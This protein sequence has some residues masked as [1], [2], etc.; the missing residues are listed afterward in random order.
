MR[1]SHSQF[2][3]AT[4]IENSSPTIGDNNKRIDQMEKCG[5]YKYWREDFALVHEMGISVLRYGPPLFRTY[6]GHNRYDWEFS[7][8]AFAEMKEL[9]LLP[10]ADLCHFG[11][12]D[13][14]GNFQNPDFPHLFAEYAGAFAQR[15]PWVQAY[16]PVNEMFICATF[17]AA[18]G[19]WNER[20]ESDFAF[21]TA[22]KHIVKANVLAMHAILERRP[23]AIF[24]QSES[25]EYFHADN[26]RAIG[27]AEAKNAR[28]FLS[29][30]LNYGR[31]VNSDVYEYLMDNGMTRGEY[32]FFMNNNLKHHC[33]LGTD[34]Y[35]TNEHRVAA[36]G[37]T[38]ASGE[39]FGFNELAR[40]YYDRYRLPVMH[41]ETNIIEGPSGL[42]AVNW[43]WKQFA[44]V[45]RV[46]NS[47]VPTLGF[48]WYSLTDQVD[49]DTALRVENNNQN[50]LGLYDLDR[51]IRNVGR[52]YKQLIEEWRDVLPTQSECLILPLVYPQE[53][54]EDWAVRRRETMRQHRFEKIISNDQ[55]AAGSPSA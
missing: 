42:E 30:D 22:L 49:W 26:P 14:I 6:I 4:G 17:S 35:V 39:I 5:H 13:W 44:N 51:N 53:Y 36:D 50:A 7:D 52:S 48:T 47:G 54:G 15:Y 21:V 34:Y 9:D 18:Y 40:Q 20:L 11:V 16:T 32:H 41:T 55:A 19:W 43:L 10:V 31:R 33:I 37:M 38:R 25:S 2:L 46:R 8:M 3:F 27:P 12:P 1:K 28:R 29:L 23:D 24:I 45:L